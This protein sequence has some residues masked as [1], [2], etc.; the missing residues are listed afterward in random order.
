MSLQRSFEFA[1]GRF[2]KYAAPMA[3]GKLQPGSDQPWAEGWEIVVILRP[4]ML[5]L[6]SDMLPPL[7]VMKT[8]QDALHHF[9]IA[10]KFQK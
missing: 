4:P 2:Y 9:G 7:T 5:L 10:L 8:I 3:Q 1:H 6:A